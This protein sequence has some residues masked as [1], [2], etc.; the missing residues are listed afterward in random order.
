MGALNAYDRAARGDCGRNPQR[1]RPRLRDC[2]VRCSG[3]EHFACT[4]HSEHDGDERGTER[5]AEQARGRDHSTGR[6]GTL[7]RYARE[8]LTVIRRLEETKAYSGD[9]LAP[10]DIERARVRRHDSEQCESERHHTE[11]E[12]GKNP[13]W[14]AV[15]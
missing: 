5:L 9:D 12:C 7:A 1:N 10:D 4:Q 11:S 13:Y 14:I 2:G 6:A 8:Q 3:D 15:G